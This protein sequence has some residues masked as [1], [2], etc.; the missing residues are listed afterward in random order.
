MI[1]SLRMPLT[2]LLMRVALKAQVPELKIW[3]EGIVYF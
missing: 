2:R 1:I 3:R